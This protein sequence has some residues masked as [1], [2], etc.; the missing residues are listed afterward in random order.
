MSCNVTDQLRP[1]H[2]L[3]GSA[4]LQELEKFPITNH[5]EDTIWGGIANCH[6][7]SEF[8]VE[9]L[10]PIQDKLREQR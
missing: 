5:V 10:N 6:S 2:L 8:E 4:S 1:C 9:V 3:H 7:V